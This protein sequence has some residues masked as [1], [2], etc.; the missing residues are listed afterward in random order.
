MIT[1]QWFKFQDLAVKQL[2]D[3]LA[4]RAS[5]FVVEQNCPYLDPDGKDERAIHLLGVED[6]KL[7]AS[8]RVIP[9]SETEKAVVFGRIVTAN[10]AR[11]KGY[12]KRL[13]QEMLQYCAVHFP[14]Y[15]IRCS[16]QL[17]LKPFYESFGFKAVSDTYLEDD[18]P[19]IAML[20]D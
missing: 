13:M 16:A 14:Q 5:I 2:Y 12:G 15:T 10:S 9:P 18:I 19:H 1:F 4:L 17:Y 11:R 6:N 20:K 8:L 3:L 7:S